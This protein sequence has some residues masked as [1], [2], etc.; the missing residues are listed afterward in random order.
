M[1]ELFNKIKHEKV[2]PF[3]LPRVKLPI[4]KEDVSMLE[5]EKAVLEMF[6]ELK[7]LMIKKMHEKMNQKSTIVG[8]RRII[9]KGG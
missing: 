8:K 6:D 7:P 3:T 1:E 4:V 9:I 2:E 5:V